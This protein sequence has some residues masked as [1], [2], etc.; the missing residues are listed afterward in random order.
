[1]NKSTIY[2]KV[3]AT[4]F[5]L[6]SKAVY[7]I[8][9]YYPSWGLNGSMIVIA[10][11]SSSYLLI[12]TYLLSVIPQATPHLLINIHSNKFIVPFFKSYLPE[13]SFINYGKLV[14]S[15][16]TLANYGTSKNDFSNSSASNYRSLSLSAASNFSTN[17][18]LK[19]LHS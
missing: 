13:I 4:Y 9:F 7:I 18:V 10:A 19:F 15:A 6:K 16:T 14:L 3:K 12:V 8:F 5:Y 1:M 2:T 11:S 17:I